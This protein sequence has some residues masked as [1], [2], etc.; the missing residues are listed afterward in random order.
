MQFTIADARRANRRSQ[1][2]YQRSKVGCRRRISGACALL[3]RLSGPSSSDGIV[4][5]GT[6]TF[7]WP[8]PSVRAITRHTTASLPRCS[9]LHAFPGG[10]DFPWPLIPRPFLLQ[11][12]EFDPSTVVDGKG[13]E[14]FSG[15]PPLFYECC[16]GLRLWVPCG[17]VMRS[18]CRRT[19]VSQTCFQNM[20]SPQ[21]CAFVYQT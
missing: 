14:A 7:C 5:K 15:D 21:R 17:V 20:P 6:R 2:S 13:T 12:R 1:C 16:Q 11:V 9:S 10:Y 8:L 18:Q 19:E 3:A 4:G